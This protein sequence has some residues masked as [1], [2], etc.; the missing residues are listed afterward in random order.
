MDSK[1]LQFFRNANPD[2]ELPSSFGKAWTDSE[3]KQLLDELAS[4]IDV[5]TIAER[6]GR[7]IGGINSRIR[8]M[9]Y[10]MYISNFTIDKIVEATKLAKE[11]INEI[12][13][14]KEKYK[15]EKK[16]K[17][18]NNTNTLNKTTTEHILHIKQHDYD[19]DLNQIKRQLTAVENKLDKLFKLLETLEVV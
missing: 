15:R 17:F 6:H 7:T 1:Y 13:D 10:K 18:N 9:S 8:D 4:N 12:I 16:E 11:Q 2:I 3:E 19:K 5:Q 14:R